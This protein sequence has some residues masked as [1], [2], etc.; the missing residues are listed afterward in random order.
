MRTRAKKILYYSG[1]LSIE[2]IAYYICI[3]LYFTTEQHSYILLSFIYILGVLSGCLTRSL[4]S[5]S[6]LLL[7]KTLA[8]FFYSKIM[9]E[10]FV[11]ARILVGVDKNFDICLIVIA[12]MNILRGMLKNGLSSNF[13]TSKKM[14]YYNDI[15]KL[16]RF[17]IRLM[18]RSSHVH[19]T[20]EMVKN[21]I[22]CT[23]DK[24]DKRPNAWEATIQEYYSVFFAIILN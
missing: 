10:L 13:S 15:I 14:E 12:L 9:Y 22:L 23:A 8:T 6:N 3:Y 11:I 18:N 5:L 16:E 20:D 17:I 21:Y 4:S 7:V 19:F 1:I 2:V 24:S